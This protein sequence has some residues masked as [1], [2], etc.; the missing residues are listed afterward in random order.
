M[1]CQLDEHILPVGWDNW[2]NVENEKTARY[3]EY[4]NTGKGADRTQRVAWSKELTKKEAKIYTLQNV[5]KQM[6]IAE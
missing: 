5:F 1:N 2:R 3:A 4:N 6:T